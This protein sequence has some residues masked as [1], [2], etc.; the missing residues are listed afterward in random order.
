VMVRD[1][2]VAEETVWLTAEA[3]ELLASRARPIVLAPARVSVPGVAP[4]NDDLGVMLPYAPL[5]YLLFACGAPP[6]LV[7]TSG[8][9]SSEPVAFEDED[10]RGRLAG[11]V[12]ALLGYTRPVTFEGLVLPSGR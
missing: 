11:L 4:D 9:R 12:A 3:R 6:R 7:M 2:S 8:N 10:A 5:H 1:E